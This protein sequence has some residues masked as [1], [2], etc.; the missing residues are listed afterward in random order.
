[1]IKMMDD[2]QENHVQDDH[3]QDVDQDDHYQD[4]HQDD[5]DQVVA[6]VDDDDD[7]ITAAFPLGRFHCLR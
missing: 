5:H 1:M 6:V 7:W 2:Y 3:D 4:D